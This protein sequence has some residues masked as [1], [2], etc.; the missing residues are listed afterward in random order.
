MVH[1]AEQQAQRAWEV[2]AVGQEL[3]E[4]RAQHLGQ[5]DLVKILMTRATGPV[6]IAPLQILSRPTFVRCA[7]NDGKSH[8]LHR[9]ATRMSH[10]FGP[11]GCPVVTRPLR[12]LPG[13]AKRAFLIS[14]SAKPEQQQ[15]R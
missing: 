4:A 11:F 14:W 15:Q 9:L 2:V 13:S 12:T 7:S 6:N 10:Q 5:V 1:A 3:V 8:F